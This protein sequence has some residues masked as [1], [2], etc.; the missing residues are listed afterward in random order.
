MLKV[1][2]GK[3][4]GKEY[5]FGERAICIV[6]R[7]VDCFPRLPDDEEHRTISRHHCLFDIN[8]PGIRVRDFGSLNGTYVNGTKIGQRDKGKVILDK[9]DQYNFPEYDLKDG[10]D[11]RLGS[12]V[13]KIVIQKF[14]ICS[15]CSKEIP[16]DKVARNRLDSTAYVCDDCKRIDELVKK[17]LLKPAAPI[18]CTQCGK[19]IPKDKAHGKGELPI[20]DNCASKSEALPKL[21][22][23]EEESK[24]ILPQDIKE[25]FL[26]IKGYTIIKE[27]G[28]GGMGVV[29]L[30]N[31]NI[32][33]EK[34]AL[35]VMLAEVAVNEQSRERFL[36]EVEYTK[37]L[38]HPNVVQM[39]DYGSWKGVFYFTLEY[40]DGGSVDK[41][42]LKLGGKLSIEEALSIILQTLD[43]LDYAHN[44]EIPEVKLTDGRIVTL[45]GL[46]HRDIKPSNFFFYGSGQNRLSKIADFGL[47]KA[48]DA[49]GLS[50]YTR[51]GS[52]AGTPVFMSRQQVIN[53][54]YSKPEADVW[55]MA[56]SLYYLL[57]GRF[58]RDFPKGKDPWY[59]VL[60]S[61]PISI[62][63]R[64]P[65]IPKR[66]ADVIDHALIDQPE[67]TFKTAIELKRALEGAL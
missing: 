21:P 25:R 62:L 23:P 11:I 17:P 29:Y 57:T 44:L 5:V 50:G 66:L 13:F 18:L 56:A 40:C 14:E 45:K 67:I 4:T 47:S 6:G 20:C 65:A 46:V 34:V 48:F 12:T 37:Y 52:S 64:N 1:T 15:V 43:G 16:E 27:L 49:A 2:E 55:S 35:K 30:A 42:M 31:N 41:W 60:Q 3:L 32:T 63:K 58:P 28:K 8:P 26:E 36:R 39:L 9:S 51:T 33:G 38:K 61:R 59:I 19:E 54:K 22:E 10:D 53:F 24:S 7:G